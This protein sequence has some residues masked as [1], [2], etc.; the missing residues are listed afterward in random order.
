MCGRAL[1]GK[2]KGGGEGGGGGIGW[3]GKYGLQDYNTTAL[4]T[5]KCFIDLCYTCLS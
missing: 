2:G 1:R 5:A 4:K 3:M